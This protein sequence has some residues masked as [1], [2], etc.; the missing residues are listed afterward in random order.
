M[1]E[2][3]RER[4]IHVRICYYLWVFATVANTH[5]SIYGYLQPKQILAENSS[6]YLLPIVSICYRSKYSLKIRVG[7]CYRSKYSLNVKVR[8]NE[9]VS[10]F[11]SSVVVK[12]IK[13]R[14]VAPEEECYP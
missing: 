3:E 6:E 9:F 11:I 13:Y 8:I 10:C 7:I 5:F 4:Q 1:R 12:V 2:R 14:F